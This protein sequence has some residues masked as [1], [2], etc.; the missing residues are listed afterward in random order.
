MEA[1]VN[2]FTKK[3]KKYRTKYLFELGRLIS[4]SRE[5]VLNAQEAPK[6]DQG[7]VMES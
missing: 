3:S 4:E 6:I 1:E 7:E 2:G 5:E